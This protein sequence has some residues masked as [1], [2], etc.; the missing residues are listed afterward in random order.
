MTSPL[1]SIIIPTFNA[2]KTLSA[3]LESVL[4]QSYQQ[5]ELLI[6]DGVSTDDTLSVVKKYAAL[7]AN[8]KWVSEKDNGIYDAMNKSIKMAKGDWLFF[9]GSDDALYSTEVLKQLA[10]FIKEDNLVEVI[11]GNVHS[12]RF[13]GFYDGVFTTKKILDQNICHQAIFLRKTVFEKV[14]D[15]NLKYKA[16]ADWDHNLKWFLSK[17]VEKKYFDIVIADY[18]DGGFSSVHGDYLFNRDKRLN[19]IC[20]GHETLSWGRKYSILQYEFLKSIKNLDF[21]K[22]KAVLRHLKFLFI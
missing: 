10:A 8:I 19:Y 20:Y 4:N 5:F 18:E 6:V 2:A 9:L 22:T 21:E 1:F 17:K 3:S 13:D 15:F 11:Y 16:Q 12:K 7:S 14:G